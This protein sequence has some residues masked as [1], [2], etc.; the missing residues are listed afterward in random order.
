MLLLDTCLLLLHDALKSPSFEILDSRCIR[1]PVAGLRC[2]PGR[3]GSRVVVRSRVTAWLPA[4][5]SRTRGPPAPP[6]DHPLCATAQ[7]S[8]AQKQ[9]NSH[10]DPPNTRVPCRSPRL[11]GHLIRSQDV[12]KTPKSCCGLRRKSTQTFM[13]D[14]PQ[15]GAT[16]KGRGPFALR[17][18]EALNPKP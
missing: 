17:I 6:P 5:A 3:I 13:T 8:A 11:I 18:L 2:Q 1:L 14:P 4:E 16:F 9:E 10:Q 7:D 12:N 15:K